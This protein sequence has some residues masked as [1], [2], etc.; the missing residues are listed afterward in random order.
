M[1]ELLS[2]NCVDAKEVDLSKKDIE[3]YLD[4]LEGWQLR[5]EKTIQKK[6]SFDSFLNAIEFVNI[7]ATVAESEDHH[8]DIDIRFNK[9]E[10]TLSTHSAGKLTLCDFIVAAKINILIEQ[11]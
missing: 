2:F 5:D 10:L 8:P 6:F 9:V 7:V 1:E 3:R 4:E 11:I